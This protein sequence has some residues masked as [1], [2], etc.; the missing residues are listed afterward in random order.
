MRRAPWATSTVVIAQVLIVSGCNEEDDNP[1]SPADPS[2]KITREKEDWNLAE[3]VHGQ[4]K[5]LK[6]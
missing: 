1:T 2:N 5:P 3:A 4:A 6:Y